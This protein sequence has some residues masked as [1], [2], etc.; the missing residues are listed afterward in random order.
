MSSPHFNN[1][2]AVGGFICYL[3]VILGTVNHSRTYLGE[4]HNVCTVS[5]ISSDMQMKSS[6]FIE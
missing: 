3:Y 6:S 5:K 1:I 4:S 2:T